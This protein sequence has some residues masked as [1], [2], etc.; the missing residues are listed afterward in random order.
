MYSERERILF[1]KKLFLILLISTL[2][3]ISTGCTKFEYTIDINKKDQINITQTQS[4]NVKFFRAIS[5]GFDVGFK[6]S[7]DT[8]SEKYKKLGYETNVYEDD[9][10]SGLTIGKSNLTI[11]QALENLPAGFDKKESTFIA[12]KGFVKS[13]YKI[14]LYYDIKEALSSTDISSSQREI[15]AG[16]P[17]VVISRDIETKNINGQLVNMTA[18]KEDYESIEG[19]KPSVVPISNLTIK[20]PVK[21]RINNADK[22][23]NDKEY[24]WNLAKEEQPVEITLEYEILDFSRLIISLSLILLLT[25]VFY[26]VKKIQNSDVVKGL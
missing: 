3:I 13:S 22:V 16:Q 10:F 6:R 17:N 12:N 26:M 25:A 23:L 1:M 18:I 24:Q 7:V 15:S 14:H 19:E 20:I 5:P 2:T 11:K 9:A 21:A 4:F 8:L